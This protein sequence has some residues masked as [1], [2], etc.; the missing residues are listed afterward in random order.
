MNKF[1]ELQDFVKK[2]GFGTAYYGTINGET[3][4]LSTGIREVYFNGDDFQIIIGYVTRF[5]RGDFGS[6]AEA[7]KEEKPGHE[8]GCYPLGLEWED[9]SDASVW[10][11][12][13]GDAIIV[14]FKFER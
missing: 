6:A 5:E 4:Y 14:Y 3:V 2:K 11:H 10:V 1:S 7:G 8:Y 13:D 12:R 9:A